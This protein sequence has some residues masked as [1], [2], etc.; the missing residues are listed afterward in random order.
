[1]AYYIARIPCKIKNII[2]LRCKDKPTFFFAIEA[3]FMNLFHLVL[4]FALACPSVATLLSP[5]RTMQ[6]MS[7]FY[8]FFL[9]QIS[10]EFLSR[11]LILSISSLKVVE[12]FEE[13]S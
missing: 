2:F 12:N 9:S 6:L 3:Y 5:F 1:M 10:C 8:M 13:R 11:K 4:N 7:M